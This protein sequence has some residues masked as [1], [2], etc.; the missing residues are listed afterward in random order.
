MTRARCPY[1]IGDTVT[2]WTVVP[3]E[4]RTRQQ[5]EQV[6]GTVVQIGSGWAGV[7]CGTAYLW[8][9]LPSGREAQVLIQGAVR[10]AP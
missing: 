1:E 4:D 2:G 9:R 3:P 10:G 6:T 8:L 7:D 5:P